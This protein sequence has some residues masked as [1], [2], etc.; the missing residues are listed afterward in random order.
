MAESILQK[1]NRRA[2]RRLRNLVIA[3]TYGDLESRESRLYT[4]AERLVDELQVQ[5]EWEATKAEFDLL[6]AQDHDYHVISG[7]TVAECD[8]CTE[9]VRYIFAIAAETESELRFAHGD[10]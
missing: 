8:D 4:Q 9:D 1:A 6:M 2:Q 5:A 3:R 7:M 10:R